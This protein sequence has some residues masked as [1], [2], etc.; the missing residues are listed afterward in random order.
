MFD[1][2]LSAHFQ[3]F[4]NSFNVGVDESLFAGPALKE[5]WCNIGVKFYTKV[6]KSAIQ[7]IGKD[8]LKRK[9]AT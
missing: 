6:P 9:E 3:I 2:L 5:F 7:R 8:I 1:S 4:N